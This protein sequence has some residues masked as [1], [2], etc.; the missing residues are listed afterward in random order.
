MYFVCMSLCIFIFSDKQHKFAING[1]MHDW[2]G[3]K[4]ESPNAVEEL[5]NCLKHDNVKRM[6]IVLEVVNKMREGNEIHKSL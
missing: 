5:V 1:Y 6:D 2:R 4:G 3:W